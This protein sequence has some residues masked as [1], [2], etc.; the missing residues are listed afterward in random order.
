MDEL[1]QKADRMSKELSAGG[2]RPF[3]ALPV[4]GRHCSILPGSRGGVRVNTPSH[5]IIDVVKRP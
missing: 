2:G 5:I 3:F 4:Q 1:V